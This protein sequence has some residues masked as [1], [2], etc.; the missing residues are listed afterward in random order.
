MTTPAIT[1]LRSTIATALAD[2]TNT[3]WQTFSYVPATILPYSVIVA[4][5]EPMLEME[6]NQYAS[7]S[8]LATL[9]IL[10]TVPIMDNQGNLAQLEQIITDVFNLLAAS[11]LNVKVERVSSPAVLQLDSGDLLTAD[12]IISTLTS[13]S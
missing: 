2:P 3:K 9:R 13:W 1:T 5:G 12:I 4:W 6:N 8:P 7:V 11:S 10:M